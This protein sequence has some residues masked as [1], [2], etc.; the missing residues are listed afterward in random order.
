M[1]WSNQFRLFYPGRPRDS[2]YT[3]RYWESPTNLLDSVSR[4]VLVNF[5]ILISGPLSYKYRVNAWI[6]DD[7]NFLFWLVICFS[8]YFVSLWSRIRLG[9]IKVGIMIDVNASL[10]NRDL[11][12]EAAT[13]SRYKLRRRLH[14][15]QGLR[16]ASTKRPLRPVEIIA[17]YT[18]STQ[19]SVLLPQLQK[20]VKTRPDAHSALFVTSGQSFTSLSCRSSRCRWSRRRRRI[21]DQV[22]KGGE[23]IC[24]ARGRSDDL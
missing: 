22:A 6:S 8:D 2:T 19:P 12:T 16:T 7:D 17:S 4:R 21:F 3:R 24:S 13:P 18:D 11:P 23:L 9:D 1:G 20:L 15:G 5:I 14:P 10:L